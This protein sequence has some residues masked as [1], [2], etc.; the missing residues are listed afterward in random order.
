M[1]LT[2][3]ENEYLIC[4]KRG[5]S[6]EQMVV[7][8]GMTVDEV[9]TSSSR[10][11]S[12]ESDAALTDPGHARAPGPVIFGPLLPFAH[13]VA[14]LFSQRLRGKIKLNEWTCLKF[15]LAILQIGL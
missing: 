7:E 13:N 14:Q 1:R 4:L 5:L 3:E 12:R 15:D 10:A 2:D 9:M 11:S 6:S 8:L